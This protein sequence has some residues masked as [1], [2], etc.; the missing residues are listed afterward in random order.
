MNFSVLP[1]EINS[2]RMFS[3]AGS[4]PMLAAAAAWAGLAD[5][6]G[7]AAAAFGSV[8]SGLAGGRVRRGRVRR[9]RRWRR[10]R[11]RIRGG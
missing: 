9:R 8:T 4:G 5:E 3:G 10:W 11:L 7:S 1:P 6:L 2:F